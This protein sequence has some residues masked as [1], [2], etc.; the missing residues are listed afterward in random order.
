M[1]ISSAK[2][3]KYQR[4]LYQEIYSININSKYI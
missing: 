1:S 2:Q 4:Y 3:S